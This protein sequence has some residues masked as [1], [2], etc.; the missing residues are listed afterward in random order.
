MIAAARTRT[1]TAA[2]LALALG[3]AAPA[4]HAQ[5]LDAIVVRASAQGRADLRADSLTRKALAEQ[6]QVRGWARAATLHKMSAALRAADDPRGDESLRLAGYLLYYAGW[7]RESRM[8]FERAAAR[9]AARG[10]V[11]GSAQCYLAAGY[12]ALDQERPNLSAR[13]AERALAL[14]D[15]PSLT[16]EQRQSILRHIDVGASTNVAS[17]LSALVPSPAPR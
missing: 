11:L 12:V 14:A 8:T 3:A 4:A 16:P 13:L 10:D 1:R 5:R 17:V 9:A 15:S 7:Q 2:L 6:E